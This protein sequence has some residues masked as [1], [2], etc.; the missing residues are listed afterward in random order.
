MGATV[1]TSSKGSVNVELNVV[2]FI[3]LM[4]CLTAF[5]LVTAVWTNLAQISIKPKG[6]GQESSQE[7]DEE[8]YVKC[9][10]L[11]TENDIWVGLSRV[12]D[13]RQIR[14]EGEDY[15]WQLL[16]ATLNEHKKSSFLAKPN[17]WHSTIEIGAEDV[18]DYQSIITTM[19]TALAAGFR[20]VGL[21]DPSS[22]TARPQL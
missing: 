13:F 19:D 1:G 4:S 14:R 22:L 20:D 2:P 3:D 15:N 6:I 5:L 8:E 12:Q 18:V 17:P 16:E 9:S 7:L 21:A 10:V 11:I